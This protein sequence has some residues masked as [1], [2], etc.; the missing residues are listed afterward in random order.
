MARNVTLLDIRTQCRQRADMVNSQFVSDSELDSYIN[1]SHTELYDLLINEYE[2]YHATSYD[3]AVVAGTTTY[4][5]PEDFYK[6]LGVDLVV[7][8]Q[9]N[10]VTLKPFVFAERNAYVFTPTWNVVGLAYLRYHLIDNSIRF[11][12]VPT[13]NQNVKLW[14]VPAVS[15]LVNDN[16][17]VDGVSGWEDYIV[18]DCCIKMLAKEESDPSV[19]MRQKDE[20]RKRIQIMAANRDAGANMRISDTTKRLPW[21][22]WSFGEGT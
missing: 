14:Y 6:L 10:A 17:T 22:F 16:D 18:A 4:D 13:T 3:L 7:D 2:D 21:E 15:K 1:A 5:L 20:L 9:G 11:V 12:P 8:S 19:F